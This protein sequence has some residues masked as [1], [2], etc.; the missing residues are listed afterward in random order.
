MFSLV[1]TLGG[2]ADTSSRK[3]IESEIRKLLSGNIPIPNYDKKKVSFPER[4]TLFDYNYSP[5]KGGQPGAAH[6]WVLWTDYIDLNEKI[7][8]NILPQ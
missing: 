3:K 6:E 8:K 2:S 1:W 5:K 7:P 4:N